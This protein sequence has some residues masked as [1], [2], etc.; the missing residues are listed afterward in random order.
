MKELQIIILGEAGTGKST[1]LLWLEKQLKKKDFFVEA[2]LKNELL[3][4]GDEAKFR[5]IVRLN[6][7]ESLKKIK[8]EVKITLTSMQTKRGSTK[9]DQTEG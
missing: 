5:N 9:N 4:Y 2:N 7:K 1:M 6:S 8:G 3:D